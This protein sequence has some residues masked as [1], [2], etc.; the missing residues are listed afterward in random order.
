[1]QRVSLEFKIIIPLR[2]D[3][4]VEGET[5]K[6]KQSSFFVL[7]CFFL[8]RKALSL[9]NM[10]INTCLG[11]L[12]VEEGGQYPKELPKAPATFATP[13]KRRVSHHKFLCKFVINKI[14]TLWMLSH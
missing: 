12:F 8:I 6:E 10:N 9:I 2:K 13:T 5:R 4:T 14:Q 7:L 3:K 1:M 11:I